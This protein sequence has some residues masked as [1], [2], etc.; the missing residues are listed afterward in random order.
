MPLTPEQIDD[1]ANLTLPQLEKRSWTDLS[2]EYPEYASAQ[3]L[4]DE[5]ITYD[6]G[7][8]LVWKL[9]TKNTGNARISGL[10]AQNAPKTD[11]ITIEGKVPWSKVQTSYIYDIDEPV[12]QQGRTQIVDNLAVRK[13]AALN[14]LVELNEEILW[15]D[16]TPASRAPRGV[17]HYIVLDSSSAGGWGGGNPSNWSSIGAGTISSVDVPR[18]KNW[19]FGWSSIASDDLIRKIKKA[20]VFTNFH[21][22]N[23]FPE[24]TKGPLKRVIY[25][26]YR[27]TEPLER[28]SEG[29]NDNHGAD[30]ARYMGQ[31]VASGVPIRFVH[32]LEAN[33]VKSPLFGVD[34][35]KL[36]P[37]M[38]KGKSMREM[39]PLQAP[40]QSSV[41]E[42]YI[43]TWMNYTCFDRRRLWGGLEA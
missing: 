26:T 31:T 15:N 22:P 19:T 35:S 18:W 12:F 10:F 17:P 36:K 40:H 27:V 30:V 9:Q 39:P 1:L 16:P 7:T 8:E 13:H 24:L 33:Y 28:F 4:R 38:Q 6:G 20:L 43:D 23:P 5:N 37:F 41:R 25:S 3:I 29:R 14:D 2:M 32:A 11:N 34:W 42:V 21:A